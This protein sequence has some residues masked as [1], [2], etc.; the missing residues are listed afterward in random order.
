MCALNRYYWPNKYSSRR[1][2]IQAQVKCVFI[3]HQK[4]DKDNAKKIA[5]YLI[6]AGVDVYLD[7]YD[8]DLKTQHQ[9]NNPKGVTDSICKGINNSSH[10]LVLIS[11]NTMKSTWV[12]FEIGYGYDK[13]DLNVLCL[14]GIPAGGLPEYVRTVNII[15]NIYDLNVYISHFT[16]ISKDHLLKYRKLFDSANNSNPLY[17][18][19]DSSIIEKY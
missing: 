17:T 2:A 16:G 10:M 1:E 11:P 12:P 18:V 5:D 4:A 13:T 14:K 9:S 6:A 15:R 7:E 3:S 8:K 19:M